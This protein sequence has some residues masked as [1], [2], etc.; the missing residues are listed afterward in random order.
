M[1]CRRRFARQHGTHS[2]LKAF[3]LTNGVDICKE[4]SGGALVCGGRLSGI[5]SFTNTT[6]NSAWSAV[7]TRITASSIRSFIRN[8]TGIYQL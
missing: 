7:F 4:D 2:Q 5:I 6:C 3:N 1:L 8:H